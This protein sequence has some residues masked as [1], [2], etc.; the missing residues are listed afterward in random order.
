MMLSEIVITSITLMFFGLL[1][2][3]AGLRLRS[4]EPVV[5]H[6][7]LYIGLGFVSNLSRLMA[8]LNMTTLPTTTYSLLTEFTLL[9]MVLVFGALTLSFLKKER[10]ILHVILHKC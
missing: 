2:V 6:L 4:K 8:G 10:K 3:L 1:L 5:F 7:I 9:A